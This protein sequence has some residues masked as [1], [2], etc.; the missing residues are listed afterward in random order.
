MADAQKESGSVPDVCPAY[1]PIYSDN[2]TWPSATVIIP[3]MLHDQY[4]DV[5]VIARHYPSA[6]RWVDYMSTFITNNIIARDTY[7]DWCVPPEEQTLIHSNDPKR[8][9]DGA[10]LATAYFYYDVQLLS[11]YAGLLNKH[12][13][14]RR[15]SELATR[16][17]RGFNERFLNTQAGYYDNGSQTSCVLPLAFGLVP[18]E[19]RQSVF[20]H[21]VKKI[22]EE[23]RNHVGTGLLGGQ[24]L[25]RVLSDNGRSDLAYT[26][27]S[28]E[29]YPSWGYMVRKGATTV[30]ELW[31]GDTADPAMN[32]G[33]HV[34][35]VG[36]LAIWMH[37]YLAGIRPDPLEPG[38]KRLKMKPEVPGDL[39]YVRASHRS[40]YGLISSE[41]RKQ[42]DRFTWSITVPPNTTATL[43]VPAATPDDVQEGGK[44]AAAGKDLRFVEFKDGRAVYEVRSG[45]YMFESRM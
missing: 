19:Y 16:L 17:K 4:G 3:G 22:T 13:D 23:T 21:L 40:P 1:W 20:G 26:I 33:N 34:M 18:D 15:Y 6:K 14:A 30:W 27:A 9:T 32:S 10:L 42:D 25:M 39:D 38:F 28:Q 37:E 44:P 7:G 5:E 35:L 8:K 24:W 36:D 11:R 45:A 43:H 29:T 2:V 41:W 31:N 12:M